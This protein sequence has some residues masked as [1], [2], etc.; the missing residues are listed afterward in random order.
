MGGGTAPGTCGRAAKRSDAA[1][2]LVDIT[3]VDVHGGEPGGGRTNDVLL[4]VLLE[5]LIMA[6]LR[7]D[8]KPWRSRS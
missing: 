3:F 7:G 1:E 8:A 2:S 5:D 6:G 4:E